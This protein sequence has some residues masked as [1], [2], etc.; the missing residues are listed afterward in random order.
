MLA[1]ILA[2]QRVLAPAS[3][4]VFYLAFVAV[5]ALKQRFN[6]S[7][8]SSGVA[9]QRSLPSSNKPL[10]CITATISTIPHPTSPPFLP[11]FLLSPLFHGS[12]L[13]KHQRDLSYPNGLNLLTGNNSR[14]T[15]RPLAFHSCHHV[16]P[17]WSPGERLWPG[18]DLFWWCVFSLQDREG[19][20]STVIRGQAKFCLKCEWANFHQPPSC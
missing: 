8:P 14:S 3:T 18:G 5:A 17:Q 12:M 19:G 9:P 2:S 7:P 13:S 20:P 1:V 4:S 11:L 6:A 10:P 15:S 16:F